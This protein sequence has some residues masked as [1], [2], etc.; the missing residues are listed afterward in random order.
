M[1]RGAKKIAIGTGIVIGVLWL[2]TKLM[3]P[4]TFTDM[5]EILANLY[6][7]ELCTCRYVIGQSLDRCFEN[8]GIIMRPTTLEWNASDRSVRVR[9]LWATSTAHVVSERFGCVR[10]NFGRTP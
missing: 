3:W 4:S 9:V 6:A 1:K 10:T 7:K 2:Y 8:H 5:P